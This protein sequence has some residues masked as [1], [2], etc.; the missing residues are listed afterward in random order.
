MAAGVS[1]MTLKAGQARTKERLLTIWTLLVA[2]GT[3]AMTVL[4]RMTVLAME[5]V[6]LTGTKSS[7]SFNFRN[8]NVLTKTINISEIIKILSF[9]IW[10]RAV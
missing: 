2:A 9:F 3:S 4:I 1:F 8:F 6:Q 5:S 7:S 10:Y